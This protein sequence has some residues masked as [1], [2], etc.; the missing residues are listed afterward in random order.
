[1]ITHCI[2]GVAGGGHEVGSAGGGGFGPQCQRSM[3]E[4]NKTVSETVGRTN[5][6][7][8]WCFNIISAIQSGHN[9]LF[10]PKV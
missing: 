7:G 5:L 6:C 9:L 2:D 3:Y 1:M 10:F 4:G 8:E